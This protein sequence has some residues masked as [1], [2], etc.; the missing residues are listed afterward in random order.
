MVKSARQHLAAFLDHIQH[1]LPAFDKA[2]A[3]QLHRAK[4]II[5]AHVNAV[6]FVTAFEIGQFDH[7]FIEHFRRKRVEDAADDGR[8]LR[9]QLIGGAHPVD[10]QVDIPADQLGEVVQPARAAADKRHA[11][12]G[13]LDQP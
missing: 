7:Q 1:A 12:T 4:F 2:A 8:I 6:I 9:Q 3:E 11:V 10:G 5:F 13:S